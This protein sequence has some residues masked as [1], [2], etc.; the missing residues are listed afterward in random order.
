MVLSPFSDRR[1]RREKKG[2]EKR[3]LAEEQGVG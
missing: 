3:E 2:R 1:E